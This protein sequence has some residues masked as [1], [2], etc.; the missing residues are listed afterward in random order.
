MNTNQAPNTQ[1]STQESWVNNIT[2]N[3][4]GG[5]V[6]KIS[7]GI[8]VL[9]ILILISKIIAGVVKRNI[10]RNMKDS[11][12]E[13]AGKI[14]K[15][16]GN[17][18]FYVL[19]LFAFFISFEIMGMNIGLLISGVSL[20]LGLAFKEVLGNMFAGMMILYTKEFKMGDII[21]VQSDQVYFGRIEEI[22][23]RHTIIRTLDLRQVVIPNMTMI[24]KP[25]KT[26]SSENIVK[27]NTTIG[28]HYES[29]VPKA[30]EVIKNAI[31]SFDFVKEKESTTV[32]VTNFGES[33]IDLKC[34]FCFDPNCGIIGDF[35]VG[36]INEKIGEEFG[37]NGIQIPY[38]HATLTFE[39]GEEKEKLMQNLQKGDNETKQYEKDII[40]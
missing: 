20:G 40:S 6:L 39:K 17:I 1:T 36:Y 32:Y 3:Q 38:K 31:N 19:I 11:N 9:I 21:E 15:L 35:A 22:T 27:L 8:V 7:T 29:D 10:K 30:I 25:I 14:G 12:P 33:S 24:S 13:G 2:D 26:F 4:V 5:Y 37:K 18:V 28:I 16:M 34:I 23:I